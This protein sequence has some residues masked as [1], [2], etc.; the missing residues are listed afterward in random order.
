MEFRHLFNILLLFSSFFCCILSS[1]K[2]LMSQ[3]WFRSMCVL[4]WIY[5]RIS[6]GTISNV[7]NF[8]DVSIVLGIRPLLPYTK[9]RVHRS[10]NLGNFSS[11]IFFSKIR[12]KERLKDLTHEMERRL[13]MH[14]AH[15]IDY[16]IGGLDVMRKNHLSTNIRETIYRL[17]QEKHKELWF[18]SK[19][20]FNF[21]YF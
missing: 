8:A 2:K 9:L 19:I 13:H 11:L 6:I 12:S 3:L 21:L 14:R 7:W 15:C 20:H 18:D 17:R 4:F 1:F 5:V 10:A 16:S